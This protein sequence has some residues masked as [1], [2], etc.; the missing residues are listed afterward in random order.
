MAPRLSKAPI[1]SAVLDAAALGERPGDLAREL[2]AAGVDWIQLRDR[3]L[4]GQALLELTRHLVA[5]RDDRVRDLA[6]GA[7][8]TRVI[9]NRRIDIALSAGA[10]GVHLGFDALDEVPARR[11]LSQQACLG[12]SLHSVQ[13]VEALAELRSEGPRYIHL[14]P[15]WN[16]LSKEASRPAL[17]IEE[18]AKACRFGLP[19]LAQGGI[20]GAHARQAIAAGAAGVAV[21]GLIA[22]APDPI[23]AVRRLRA[24]LDGHFPAES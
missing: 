12:R 10:N 16:P 23:A 22:Q 17:G 2:F 11:L 7:T 20:E 14:A 4:S 13:E 21:T 1:L 3:S 19:V 15:I 18:L 8:E 5:A 6:A 24:T 9:V